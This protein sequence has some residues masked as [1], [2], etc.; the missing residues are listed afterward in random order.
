MLL[1]F[2]AKNEKNIVVEHH[3]LNFRRPYFGIFWPKTTKKRYLPK[4]IYRSFKPLRLH[5][6]PQPETEAKRS[7][8]E[9]G[10]LLSLY[11]ISKQ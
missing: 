10:Y 8:Q 7:H 4:M 1:S 6:P 2:H 9:G 11:V 5:R 3:Y